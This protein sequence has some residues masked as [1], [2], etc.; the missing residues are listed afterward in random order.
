[1]LPGYVSGFY[2]YDDC[3]IDLARLAAFAKARLIHAEAN[4]IDTLVRLRVAA[5]A[6]CFPLRCMPHAQQPDRMQR[7]Y[8][9]IIADM[10]NTTC[11]NCVEALLQLQRKQ[12][13][14]AVRSI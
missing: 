4:G 3:H 1:M 2:S 11:S 8:Q 10:C 12:F 5:A 14:I 6:T 9:R 7:S 13:T